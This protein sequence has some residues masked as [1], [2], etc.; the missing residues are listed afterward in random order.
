MIRWSMRVALLA[1]LALAG[2]NPSLPGAG[3]RLRVYLIDASASVRKTTG[4]DAFTTDDALRLA[5][6]DLASLRPSDRVALV[7]FG[8][9]PA[10]LVPLTRVSDAKFPTRIEGV[11]ASSTDLPAALDTA[12]ALAEGGEI[13]LFSDGHS[14]AGRAPVERIRVPVH[15]F[16][17]GPVGGVDASISAIDAPATGPSNQPVRIRVTVEATGAWRGEL[18]SGSDR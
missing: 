15:A 7:A 2:V 10:I 1:L 16:P 8:S 4:T 11:D 17:L 18:N 12:Q 5:K 14:T 3:P 13:V 9:A 6:H